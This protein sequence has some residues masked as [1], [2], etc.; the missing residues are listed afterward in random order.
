MFQSLMILSYIQLVKNQI[1]KKEV[2]L[3]IQAQSAC[4]PLATSYR[5]LAFFVGIFL[6][7]A[8]VRFFVACLA[9]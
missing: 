4:S 5:L 7:G 1:G 8:F 2:F 3:I 9:A 6:F